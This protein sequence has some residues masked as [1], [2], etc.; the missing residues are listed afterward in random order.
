MDLVTQQ[1]GMRIE[2]FRAKILNADMDGAAFDDRW[3]SLP[4]LFRAGLFLSIAIFVAYLFLFGTRETLAK[5]IALD[6]L[7]SSEEILFDD[8]HF[9]QL[10][11]L[12]IDE[13][14]RKLIQHIVTLE[15]Q[16]TQK[17]RRVG[18]VYGARH[19]R[20]TIA[21]LMQKLNYRVTKAEW[22]KVFDL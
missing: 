16:Q 8:E 10:D 21:Y 14:D 9:E 22:V 18:I 1:D 12:I 17:L 15:D 11:T 20:T 5:N 7:P 19:M 2:R 6:D 3:S 13:R 4:V